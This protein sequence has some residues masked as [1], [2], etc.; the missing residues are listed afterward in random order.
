MTKEEW[1]RKSFDIYMRDVGPID[2]DEWQMGLFNKVMLKL[3]VPSNLRKLM[4]PWI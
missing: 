1:A 2:E 3:L 4:E